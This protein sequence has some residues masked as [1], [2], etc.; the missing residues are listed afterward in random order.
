MGCFSS[1][2]SSAVSENTNACCGEEV[3]QERWKFCKGYWRLREEAADANFI[4][5][6][7]WL[8][9][10]ICNQRPLRLPTIIHH[11]SGLWR[12]RYVLPLRFYQI[13]SHCGLQRE[14]FSQ[15]ELF[16]KYAWTEKC[17][18]ST[19]RGGPT[20]YVPTRPMMSLPNPMPAQRHP[21][22][23]R[24]CR[25]HNKERRWCMGWLHAER[26]T[27]SLSWRK[28]QRRAPWVFPTRAIILEYTLREN[29]QRPGSSLQVN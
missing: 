10:H 14:S 26:G 23:R 7:W 21:V 18:G 17:W 1:C 20:S 16:K 6:F 19:A 12:S 8:W 5:P 4:P 9:S 15:A 2:I 22:D 3:I 27:K 11:R 13:R 25:R 24:L 28:P 29:P